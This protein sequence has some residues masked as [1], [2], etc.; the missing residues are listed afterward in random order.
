V[1]LELTDKAVMQRGAASG[2]DVLPDGLGLPGGHPMTE[3]FQAIGDHLAEEGSPPLPSWT[4]VPRHTNSG[5]PSYGTSDL[6][7][8]FHALMARTVSDWDSACEVYGQARSSFGAIPEIHALMFSRTGPV[9][10]ALPM[11]DWVGGDFAHVADTRGVAPRRRAV[12]GVPAFINMALLGYANVIKY[13]VMRTPW[14]AHPNER[15]VFED[16]EHL[17]G[18]I[19]PGAQVFSDDI[20]SFD[21]SVRR[22]HQEALAHH[23]YSRWWPPATIDLWLNAQRMGVLGPP[24]STA[25]RGFLYTRDRR[26]GATTSGIITTTVDGTLIN[27]ARALTCAGAA[28][29][30]SPRAALRLLRERRWGLKIWGD[31]TVTI[32]PRGASLQ[33]YHEAGAATGF[34]AKAQEGI[35]FLMKHYD[36]TSRSVFPLAT[37]V[38]QQ[39]LWNERGGRTEE[40]ELLGLFSRTT[41]LEANPLGQEAWSIVAQDAAPLRRYGVTRRSDLIRVLADPGVREALRGGL[42][43]NPSYLGDLLSRSDRGHI[44]D[45]SLLSWAGSLLGTEIEEGARI[46]LTSVS[47][48]TDREARRRTAE[49]TSY[50]S[51]DVDN[52]GTPPGWASSI[53]TRDQAPEEE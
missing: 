44:E 46:D 10:K 41:G 39:T 43:A 20:S 1:E 28:L 30:V 36:M 9:S 3:A 37:R 6:E 40:I 17:L 42:T 49:L 13:M 22:S 50:L 4:S 12:F 24:L 16:I 5:A 7:K 31:D 47:L 53:L 32:L 27:W 26:G 38:I 25:S 34:T 14:T 19:G 52:R 35:T 2:W 15:A 23:V 11:Y 21:L 33:K 18:S 8:L 48:L 51:T 29:G 45:E